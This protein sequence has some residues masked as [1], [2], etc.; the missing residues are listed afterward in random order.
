M[1]EACIN[2]DVKRLRN[3]FVTLLL[4]SEVLWE[5]YRDNMSHDM[6]H[7]CM[8]NGGTTEDAYNNTLLLLEAKLALTNKGLHDFS[9]YRL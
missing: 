5:R 8:T 4:F 9:L 6:Q 1:W 2:Q 3:P 7:Q